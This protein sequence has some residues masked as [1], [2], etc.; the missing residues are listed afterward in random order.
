MVIDLCSH[1]NKKDQGGDSI[2]RNRYKIMVNNWDVI[3]VVVVG[4]IIGFAIVLMNF[5][6]IWPCNNSISN[7]AFDR[8]CDSNELLSNFA[9][10][11]SSNAAY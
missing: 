11:V 5:T 2:F 10:Y 7:V 3:A 6:G 4:M 9:D 8:L 1:Y